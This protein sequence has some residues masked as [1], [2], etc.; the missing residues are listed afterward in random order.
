[1]QESISERDGTG[2]L[3]PARCPREPQ[4][5]IQVSSHVEAGGRRQERE[6]LAYVQPGFD[7]QICCITLVD[8]HCSG[9]LDLRVLGNESRRLD[10]EQ[11][12]LIIN[13]NG[14][15]VAN[16]A[17]SKGNPQVANLSRFTAAKECSDSTLRHSSTI[18]CKRALPDRLQLHP[19]H[20]SS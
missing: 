13:R 19:R 10:A 2:S 8:R 18:F 14:S 3:Q 17:I 1:M 7:A 15:A 12:A 6:D 4:V 20:R 16:L 11:A 5:E 9:D